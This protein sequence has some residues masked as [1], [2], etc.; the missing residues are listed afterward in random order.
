MWRYCMLL[1]CCVVLCACAPEDEPLDGA[2]S[3]IIG[4]IAPLRGQNAIKGLEARRGITMEVEA[5][6][7]LHNGHTMSVV[8]EHSSHDPVQ[9]VAAL[10]K[11]AATPGLLA[12]VTFVDSDSML[13]IAPVAEQIGIPVLVGTATNP[14]I[15][16]GRH[17]ITQLIYDDRFQGAVAALFTR[18][19]LLLERVAVLSNPRN[20]YS[21]F[22]GE[23]YARKFAAVGG[24]VVD[25]VPVYERGFDLAA[26]L[27]TLAAQNPRPQ[28]L[29]LPL[30]AQRVID[31]AEVLHA[32]R[33]RPRMLVPDGVLLVLVREHARRLRLVEGVIGT[34][35]FSPKE[36]MS[37]RDLFSRRYS[38]IR[39]TKAE[40]VNTYSVLGI[41]SMLLLRSAMNRCLGTGLDRQC[42]RGRIRETRNLV[43]VV[44]PIDITPEGRAIRPLVVNTIKR[45]RIVYRVRV[46]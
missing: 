44:G 22:L 14:T 18:D 32:L 3:V 5:E 36:S 43:G 13:A 23:E 39:D 33:W 19:D 30:P 10:R 26:A 8:Y 37:P 6:P 16:E 21:R 31:I 15:I 28:L 35:I 2:D 42:L 34:D 40:D 38:L 24:E 17:Y 45:G 11:L 1:S 25:S 46:H 29:Y 9:A 20:T 4:V 7:T 12:V 27:N 41:E